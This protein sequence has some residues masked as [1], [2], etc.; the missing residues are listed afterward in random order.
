MISNNTR[1]IEPPIEL[2]SSCTKPE[3]ETEEEDE[4]KPSKRQSPKCLSDGV[5][6][7]RQGECHQQNRKKWAR[8]SETE[9]N[10]LLDLPLFLV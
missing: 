8:D 9:G 3:S 6:T 10:V 4:G 7:P 1:L 2:Q 5:S